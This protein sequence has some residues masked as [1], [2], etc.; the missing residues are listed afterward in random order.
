[1]DNNINPDGDT[2]N[3]LAVSLIG[4]TT[5]TT[6]TTTTVVAA[7]PPKTEA[8]KTLSPA[9]MMKS[10]PS[11]FITSILRPSDA[12]PG[13]IPLLG[14]RTDTTLTFSTAMPVSTGSELDK[15]HREQ[16]ER[17]RKEA[18]CKDV[19]EEWAQCLGDCPGLCSENA[20]QDGVQCDCPR[21][22][23][24][25]D[26]RRKEETCKEVYDDLAQCLDDCPGLCSES[27]G[28]DE[29]QCGCPR[30][31]EERERERKE[32]TCEEVYGELAQC[33]DN[34]PGLCSQNAGQVGTQCDCPRAKRWGWEG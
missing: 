5:A 8:Q 26:L 17:R 14:K 9:T 30:A 4:I 27:A 18:T 16:E 33:L 11:G 34:C 13:T 19:Y 1:M 20:G 12:E 3:T 15:I 10:V 32:E 21:R 29:V 6:T 22:E 7:A 25:Q 31:K 28:Q 23:R 24:E 2:P